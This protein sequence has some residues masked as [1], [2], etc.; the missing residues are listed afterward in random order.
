MYPLLAP[1]S[2]CYHINNAACVLQCYFSFGFFMLDPEPVGYY[3]VCGL[4]FAG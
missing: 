4:C 3:A 2:G 1:G